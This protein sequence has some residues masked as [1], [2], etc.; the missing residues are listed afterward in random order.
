MKQFIVLGSCLVFLMTGCASS[1]KKLNQADYPTQ[2]YTQPY[3]LVF[4]KTMDALNEQP[5]WILNPTNKAEGVIEVSNNQYTNWMDMD[6]QKARF[7]V[8]AVSRT[9]TS[10]QFDAEHSI[11]KDRNCEKIFDG[12]KRVLTALPPPK[13]AA[14]KPAE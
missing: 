7:L 4:K 1:I 8:K 13:E 9:Q 12:V 14:P 5:G 10:V 6:T 3:D 2:T 11:C